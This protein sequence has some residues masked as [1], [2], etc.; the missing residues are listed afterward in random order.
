MNFDLV[1]LRRSDKHARG[2]GKAVHSVQCHRVRP[3]EGSLK[4]KA[5]QNG[6]TADKVTASISDVFG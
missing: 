3:C 4:D 5:C 6:G 1:D 2:I